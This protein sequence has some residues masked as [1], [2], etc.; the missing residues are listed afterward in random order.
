VVGPKRAGS[1]L[2]ANRKTHGGAD[3]PDRDVHF[4]H[5][6]VR[7]TRALAANQP[8]I[9]VGPRRRSLSETSRTAAGSRGRRALQR[10]SA[11]ATS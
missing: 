10:R 1:G 8:V 9:S 2:Q 11:C 5:I 7:L 6:N 4:A 3:H